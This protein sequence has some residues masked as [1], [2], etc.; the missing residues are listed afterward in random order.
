MF[1]DFV[2][3]FYENVV[4]AYEEYERTRESNTAGRSKDLRLAINAATSLYH[5]REHIPEPHH[6]SR[7]QLAQMSADYDLLGDVVD[8]SKHNELSRPNRRINSAKDICEELTLTQ[9]QDDKGHFWHSEK[10]ITVRLEDGTTRDLFDMM[11][12][13][14]NMWCDILHDLGVLNKK[15]Y[16]TV[17]KIAPPLRRSE[18]GASQLDLE[19]IQGVR[20]SQRLRLQK[21][22]YGTGEVE[23]FNLEGFHVRG[24]IYKPA[25]LDIILRN[26][27][28]GKEF[29]RTIEL[30]QEETLQLEKLESD[31]Q[32]T[33]FLSDLAKRKNVTDEMFREAKAQEEN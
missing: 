7:Q 15:H 28:T 5:L 12:N 6:F 30:S 10:T 27:E 11:T 16:F 17:K 24:R 8:A 22:N 29:K 23:P 25:S 26:D 32:R 18:S 9:Y 4:V 3:Y 13:V 14:L 1:D 20:F 31:E 2:A 21:Y 19:I 33:S